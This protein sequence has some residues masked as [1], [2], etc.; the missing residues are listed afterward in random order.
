LKDEYG[1]N[2]T[3]NG[4]GH[5]LVAILDDEKKNEMILNDFYLANQ[6]SY[7]SGTVRYQLQDLTPGPHTIKVRAWNISNNFSEV[8]LPFVVKSDEKLKL[9]HVL[10]YPN[11]FT[12]HTSFYFEHNQPLETYDILIHIFTVSGKLVKTLRD[13]QF[14][15]GNRSNPIE[16]D[17]R[18]EYGDKI[19][20]GVYLYRLTVRNSQGETVEKI[21]KI[22]LL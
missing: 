11:P 12:T 7:N 3:G 5:D 2:T 14:L 10:N 17:G 15:E 8:E 22:A 9:A 18:D 20:K 16:W 21:E 4:I 13:T 19:G 6:D 1:I